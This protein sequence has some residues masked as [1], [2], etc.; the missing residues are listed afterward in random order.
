MRESRVVT[1]TLSRVF[2]IIEMFLVQQETWR[3]TWRRLLYWC[4][5]LMWWQKDGHN[6][7]FPGIFSGW[8]LRPRGETINQILIGASQ[9]STE[10][11]KHI[12]LRS[13]FSLPALRA[14]Q[15]HQK[16]KVNRTVMEW[17]LLD[18]RRRET[19]EILSLSPTAPV[20]S[21]FSGLIGFIIP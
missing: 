5:R 14:S 8:K 21:D 11:W 16:L 13:E 10:I 1:L 6:R 18:S 4:R 9:L 2:I 3:E 19:L 7:N 15:S 12:N 17:I 20:K